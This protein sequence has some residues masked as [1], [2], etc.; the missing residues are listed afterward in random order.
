MGGLHAEAALSLPGQ[1]SLVGVL[2]D[3]K[4]QPQQLRQSTLP[5][6]SQQLQQL[7]QLLRSKPDKEPLQTPSVQLLQEQ[8]P[9]Q[10]QQPLV[11]GTTAKT[12]WNQLS[13][14]AGRLRDA[15]DT[16]HVASL[17]CSPE[18]PKS[19]NNAA[20]RMEPPPNTR[21][22]T[23][24]PARSVASARA[25]KRP[26][27]NDL[28]AVLTKRPRTLQDG[29]AEHSRRLVQPDVDDIETFGD[30]IQVC[31]VAPSTSESIRPNGALVPC[32]QSEALVVADEDPP[33]SP[34]PPLPAPLVEQSDVTVVAASPASATP[35]VLFTGFARGD[36]HRLKRCVSKLGGTAVREFPQAPEETHAGQVRLVTRCD[37]SVK[38]ADGSRSTATQPVA[39]SRTIKYFEALLVGAWVLSPEWVLAS[40][41]AGR[42]LPEIDFELA[43]DTVGMGGPAR[44]RQHGKELFKG[45][46]LH[47]PAATAS[48]ATSSSRSNAP[49]AKSRLTFDDADGGPN[50]DDLVRLA[51]LGGA[52][53]LS[54]VC[55]LPDSIM[56]PPHLEASSLKQ[57]RSDGAA[58]G[59]S[60]ASSTCS[61]WWRQP[62]AVVGGNAGCSSASQLGWSVLPTAWMLDSI[63][64]GEIVAPPKEWLRAGSR[65]HK[66]KKATAAAGSSAA[67]VPHAEKAARKR[68][69]TPLRSSG[70]G[71]RGLSAPSSGRTRQRR[72]PQITAPG[73]SVAGTSVVL[74][75]QR[76]AGPV[77]EVSQEAA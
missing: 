30:H 57:L 9:D 73:T 38:Q 6:Q 1:P 22:S 18:Q 37:A 41:A 67:P 62:I 10:P 56:D 53:V 50:P 33:K 51:R 72:P 32:K 36:L 8:N 77:L 68:Q 35:M 65:T 23:P 16:A 61:H 26:S 74:G 42:W 5:Q 11:T 44:G 40:Y 2:Q 25:A 31:A 47:F 66:P 45:L 24:T 7:Q 34:L 69:A 12:P 71:S 63:S 76:W 48:S 54:A 49:L 19:P 15:E 28:A 70:A 4:P 43:G 39:G 29:S 3:W 46:R 13:S 17:L 55:A 60:V 27:V 21:S 64:M 14:F 59:S 20:Q 52:E 75:F 58:G